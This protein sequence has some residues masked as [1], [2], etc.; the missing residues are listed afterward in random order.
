MSHWQGMSSKNMTQPSTVLLVEVG[1]RQTVI[2]IKG[3]LGVFPRGETCLL[4]STGPFKP[5]P[6]EV[7]VVRGYPVFVLSME[8]LFNG[9][10][11]DLPMPSSANGQWLLV[12]KV[13]RG[14]VGC[15]IDAL[16]A[17]IES[18]HLTHPGECRE[19]AFSECSKSRSCHAH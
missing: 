17:L 4:S 18:D 10:S 8:A 12:Y 16:P 15:W 19:L 7:Q 1:G 11:S 2:P 6:V 14:H 13:K 3:V 9:S 5:S